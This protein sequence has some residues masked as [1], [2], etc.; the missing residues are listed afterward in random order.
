MSILKYIFNPIISFIIP[1]LSFLLENIY[2]QTYAKFY[3]LETIARIPYFSYLAV[4]H[5]YQSF[6]QHPALELLDLHYKETVNEEY[7]L[8]IMEELGGAEKWYNRWIA[9]FLG[10]LY[11]GAVFIL[12]IIS[13]AS[14]YFLMEKVES[15]AAK[16][17][18]EFLDIKE[19]ILKATKAEGFALKYYF[20]NK[21][22]MTEIEEDKDFVPTLF[23]VFTSIR[24]DEL[25]HVSDM[26]KTGN[27]K[28]LY[29][30]NRG[31]EIIEDV[32][33]RGI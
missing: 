15:F 13:P 33:K 10:L 17:Y 4:L 31:Q 19:G 7:H 1:I 24:N 8:M 26:Q 9:K 27:M 5:L 21:G 18:T 32:L 28:S 16:S 20:S 29:S 23:D 14:G 6:G 22:R 12:Y 3:V 25:V 11:Y 2:K 30:Q